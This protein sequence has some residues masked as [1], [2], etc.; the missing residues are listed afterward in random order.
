MKS[1]PLLDLVSTACKLFL[2]TL[3]CRGP[4]CRA[5]CSSIRWLFKCSISLYLRSSGIEE[6]AEGY[7]LEVEMGEWRPR[8]LR[9]SL[10]LLWVG[11]ED[12]SKWASDATPFLGGFTAICCLITLF[13]RPLY[14]SL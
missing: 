4:C 2:Y 5:Y 14:W 9:E 7:A 6:R 11:S 3:E 1:A 12:G 8:T 10:P 13:T